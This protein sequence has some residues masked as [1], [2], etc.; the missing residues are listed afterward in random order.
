MLKLCLRCSGLMLVCLAWTLGI[1]GQEVR[2]PVKVTIKDGKTVV[3]EAVLP[4]DPTPRIVAQQTSP[5]NF[6]LTLDG[7]RITYSPAGSI[8]SS[9]MVDGQISNPFDGINGKMIAPKPL[10][11][12]PT[13]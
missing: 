3:G 8:W 6:G 12:S 10:P 4:L 11:N 2:G 1:G 5:K 7:Q 13:G 9:A